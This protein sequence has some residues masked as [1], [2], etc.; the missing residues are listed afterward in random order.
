MDKGRIRV[1]SASVDTL[2]VAENS[3]IDWANDLY[4]T[5]VD[6]IE[7]SA[8]YPRIIKDPANDE[9]VIFYK[10]YDIPYTNQNSVLG[11]FVCMGS[12][13]AVD[14]EDGSAQLYWTSSGTYNVKGDALTYLWE[15]GG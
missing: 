10:D 1:R 9:N 7:I 4:I 8:I 12:H 11:T 14:L 13:R 15:F 5:V 3:D 2:I 6:F